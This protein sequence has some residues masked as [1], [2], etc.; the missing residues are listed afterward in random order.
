[1]RRPGRRPW[2][3]ALPE[4]GRTDRRNCR[5][6]RLRLRRAAGLEE[7]RHRNAEMAPRDRGSLGRRAARLGRIRISKLAATTFGTRSA[8]S[9]PSEVNPCRTH[10][11]RLGGTH[12]RLENAMLSQLI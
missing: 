2:A 1:M 11:D 3:I 9:S 7:L 5:H 8:N 6:L 10:V 12:P 4:D